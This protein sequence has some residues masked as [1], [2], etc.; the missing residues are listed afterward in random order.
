MIGF[1]PEPHP[2]ELM[3][4]IFSRY[5]EMTSYESVAAVARDLFFDSVR[6]QMS[7]I[8][9]S[10][11]ATLIARLPPGH[12]FTAE[13][14]IQEHTLLPF[15]GPFISRERFRLAEEGLTSA[16]AANLYGRLGVNTFRGALRVFRYCPDCIPADRRKFG[17]TYWHRIHHIPSINICASHGCY[18][19]ET[20]VPL[21]T[22]KGRNAFLTAEECLASADLTAEREKDE[23]LFTLQKEMASNARWLL[24]H[25]AMSGY[26]QNYR[27]YYVQLLYEH[28]FCTYRGVL[29]RQKLANEL[30]AFY[31]RDFLVGLKC[32]VRTDGA[33]EWINRFVHQRDRAIHPIHHLLLLQFLRQSVQSFLDAANSYQVAAKSGRSLEP[34]PFGEPPW[35]C[36]NS[37]TEHFKKNVVTKCELL[38]TQ[39]HP[40]RPRGIF[41]CSCGLAYSRVGPDKSPADRYVLD[42]YISFGTQWENALKDMVAKGWSIAKISRSLGIA[43]GTVAKQLRRLGLR[44]VRQKPSLNEPERRDSTSR[45]PSEKEVLLTRRRELL[46][47]LSENSDA[48]RSSIRRDFSGTYSWLYVHDREWMFSHLPARRSGPRNPRRSK[49]KERDAELAATVIVEAKRI[50]GLSGRPIRI[51]ASKIARNLDIAQIWSKRIDVIPLT[52]KAL[53]EVAETWEEFAVRRVEWATACLADQGVPVPSWRIAQVAGISGKSGRIPVVRSALD[54]AAVLLNTQIELSYHEANAA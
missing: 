25:S 26:S 38:P 12:W 5:S 15:F 52:N 19:C 7:A 10:N 29:N 42:R 45:H 50:R 48:S 2:D 34:M 22:A 16:K 14:F 33:E 17:E 32:E 36:L 18:L 49:W 43:E 4:S 13:R 51:S 24:D 35:P 30:T 46:E 40:R 54:R 9:P 8:F 31:T 6:I 47:I 3:F 39:L 41:R 28:G 23:H 11:L 27:N 21:T 20:V 37:A 53:L 44:T 1:F